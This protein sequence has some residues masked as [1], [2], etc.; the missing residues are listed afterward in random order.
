MSA[1]TTGCKPSSWERCCPPCQHSSEIQGCRLVELVPCRMG[2][3]ACQN[4][5]ATSI[6]NAPEENIF[7]RALASPTTATSS[8][9][10]RSQ[11]RD[12]RPSCTG[13]ASMRSRACSWT[14]VAG[15]RRLPRCCSRARRGRGKA[16]L[17]R[18]SWSGP[19]HVDGER[20]G[21]K[22]GTPGIHQVSMTV[23]VFLND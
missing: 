15:G 23:Y 14:I 1:T 22:T 18:P 9:R 5:T 20:I 6:A 2:S 3:L 11:R 10:T 17:W 13:K 7:R 4:L 8:C 19:V 21:S 16:W 12:H